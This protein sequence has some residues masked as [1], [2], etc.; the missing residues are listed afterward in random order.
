MLD[1]EIEGPAG[2]MPARQFLHFPMMDMW[3]QSW[4]LAKATGQS[5]SYDGDISDYLLAFCQQAFGQQ[6]PPAEIIGPP[7]EAPGDA[8]A[9]ERL[10][11][12]LG[13]TPG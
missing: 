4:D 10:V 1:K 6:R 2:K 3:V 7:V 8:S 13:R 5:P 11:A 12:F 9:I